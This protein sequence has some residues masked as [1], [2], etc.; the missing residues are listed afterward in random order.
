MSLVQSARL[1]GH[2]PF[3]YLGD[4]LSAPRFERLMF[5][6]AITAAFN[7]SCLRRCTEQPLIE[8]AP[9]V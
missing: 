8:V 3:A 1:N 2:D 5:G 9:F 4:V 6:A 7:A